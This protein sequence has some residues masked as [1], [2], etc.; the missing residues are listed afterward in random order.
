MQTYIKNIKRTLG[1]ESLGTPDIGYTHTV[2]RSKNISV[3]CSRPALI[4]TKDS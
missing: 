4:L 2:P 3:V 1:M